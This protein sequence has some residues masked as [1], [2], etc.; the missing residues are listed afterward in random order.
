MSRSR[1]CCCQQT[2]RVGC[3]HDSRTCYYKT[4]DA[5][6]M[7]ESEYLDYLHMA[8][9]DGGFDNLVA[10]KTT[11]SKPDGGEYSMGL[12]PWH[13]PITNWDGSTYEKD[14]LDSY[15]SGDFGVCLPTRWTVNFGN[16]EIVMVREIVG[17]RSKTSCDRCSVG[18]S[19][20]ETVLDIYGNPVNR[21]LGGW[22]FSGWGGVQECG[23]EESSYSITI[24]NILIKTTL[25]IKNELV[26]TKIAEVPVE[27]VK[28]TYYADN[29]F[30]YTTPTTGA[31][32]FQ[33]EVADNFVFA[34]EVASEPKKETTHHIFWIS[35]ELRRASNV[36]SSGY[37]D[38]IKEKTKKVISTSKAS[39]E[40]EDIVRC[41][42]EMYE[43]Y[44]LANFCIT[45][46][47]IKFGSF[48]FFIDPQ[49]PI[50]E[51]VFS[52]VDIISENFKYFNPNVDDID[53]LPDVDFNSD[54]WY[55]GTDVGNFTLSPCPDFEIDMEVKKD[56]G[57]DFTWKI[58]TIGPFNRGAPDSETRDLLEIET[59][60]QLDEDGNPLVEEIEKTRVKISVPEDETDWFCLCP[61]PG[62]LRMVAEPPCALISNLTCI[63]DGWKYKFKERSVPTDSRSL[64]YGSKQPIRYI[65]EIPNIKDANSD[66]NPFVE[67]CYKD[68]LEWNFSVRKNF[69]GACG[70]NGNIGYEFPTNHF[71]GLAMKNN[72]AGGA[73]SNFWGARR[74]NL[75]GDSY[76]P[77]FYDALPLTQ[78]NDTQSN[79]TWSGWT[80][81]LQFIYVD[82]QIDASE[83][84]VQRIRFKKEGTSPSGEEPA[85]YDIQKIIDDFDD[86]ENVKA[87]G[88]RSTWVGYKVKATTEEGNP[89]VGEMVIYENAEWKVTE[90][91]QDAGGT[92]I[93]IIFLN[94]E[95]TE[96]LVNLN[97]VDQVGTRDYVYMAS[98]M[99]L[100]FQEKYLELEP[101]K[102]RVHSIKMTDETG[103]A[104]VSITGTVNEITRREWD[105]DNKENNYQKLKDYRL[106]IDKTDPQEFNDFVDSLEEAGIIVPDDISDNGD[107]C[108][109]MGFFYTDIDGQ[110][111][112]I[113]EF[114]FQ[115]TTQK[116]DDSGIIGI[117]GNPVESFVDVLDVNGKPIE[118]PYKPFQND[119]DQYFPRVPHVFF[120]PTKHQSYYRKK[121]PIKI[122]PTQTGYLNTD[123]NILLTFEYER[124]SQ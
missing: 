80:Y 22:G 82:N 8:N 17:F 107:V 2:V 16:D 49:D 95:A 114:N 121:Y 3:T 83:N 35:D 103:E 24:K 106:E 6:Y 68:V 63:N 79:G 65:P 25:T 98:K 39:L 112:I 97:D 122:A 66:V 115:Q 5:D 86:A 48:T 72:P 33:H 32:G 67:Q 60:D 120:L 117:D 43:D 124:I 101:E 15:I 7:S 31:Y 73:F 59:Q 70:A 52:T 51:S 78:P 64:L 89:K 42:E 10:V 76:F 30:C 58:K 50:D 74:A 113:N 92:S 18:A 54:K 57:D 47:Y 56:R 12:V 4:S 109:M 94:D 108:Y 55:N 123:E 38:S 41:A 9:S 26:Y 118:A 20:G 37:S 75:V 111:K 91:F 53:N 29:V 13:Y 119:I 34:P 77:G 93:K 104:I 14:F 11:L 96:L 102:Y 21:G 81:P 19:S 40:V 85:T 69:A 45:R 27:H 87:Q 46:E 23:L 99:V 61:D 88:G 44:V 90:V 84:N 62:F 71:R 28:N 36:K 1:N 116:I 105:E 110:T 100:A